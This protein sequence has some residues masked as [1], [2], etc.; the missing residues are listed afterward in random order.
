MH[1]DLFGYVFSILFH[2]SIVCFSFRIP[3]PPPAVF[4]FL[5]GI[6][7]AGKKSG[8]KFAVHSAAF[9]EMADL[10]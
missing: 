5:Q 7:R 1:T 3:P 9:M 2:T 8:H 10:L 6:F 4:F